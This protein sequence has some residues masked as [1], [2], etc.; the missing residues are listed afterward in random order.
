[1]VAGSVLGTTPLH[2]ALPRHGGTLTIVVRLAGYR[3]QTF[4]LRADRAI[5][6][7]LVLVPVPPRA[8]RPLRDKSVNPF[9]H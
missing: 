1:V 2:H 8:M 6:Q 4:V 9:E 3:D 5:A 7:H